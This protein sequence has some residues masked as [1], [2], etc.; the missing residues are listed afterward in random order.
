MSELRRKIWSLAW[1]A[2]AGNI[3]QTLLNLV[4]M[5]I[6]G[7]VSAIALGA[8]GLGGQISWFMFPIMIAVSTGTLAIVAR[9]VGEGKLEEA[10]RVA[11]QSMYLAFL[12]GIPVMLF[13]IFFGD[14]ILRIMG[15]KG[16]VLEIG[17]EYLKV[18][19]LFYPIRFVGFVFFSALRGAGDTKTPM[20][21]NI[22][23]NVLNGVFDYLL[24][25]GKL[26]FPRLGPV[27][28][29]WASGIG[30]T[31]S[32]LIGMLL[33]LNGKLVIKPVIEWRLHLDIVEKI[34]RIGTPALLERGL[35]SFYNFLYMAIVT[36]FGE[37]ALSA[38]QIGLRVESIAYMPAFGFSIATSAL[39][40]QSLGAK[41]PDEAEKIV[42][43]S[44]KMTTIFMSVMAFVLMA[45]P[46]ILVRPFLSPTDPY[47]EEV[48]R[49]A[50]IYLIIVGISEIPLGVI[51]VLSGALRGAGDTKSPLYVT[52]ISKLLFR[53]MPSYILGFGVSLP[54]LGLE[55]KGLGVIAAWIGMSLETFI[56][57][58]LFWIV[59]R[60]GRWK[61]I[62]I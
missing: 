24:V 44:L 37:I 51:F 30:I 26:G 50:V 33:F 27:G 31:V 60:K 47:Y 59:F 13:G 12:L 57:A 36:R 2:I 53:I 42:K 52:A 45:F 17:Y 23:M 7:H 39:V 55:F 41:K 62:K 18:L 14:E 5:M 29:A 16:E 38:H 6:L 1:P 20:K 25:F 58:G 10:S 46:S 21:L 4:D 43:E 49:L 61:K 35:F 15:A 9:R 54:S 48:K 3:S 56:S 22:L 19:F 11:E 8:V 40:G 32:F 28:A 34:L